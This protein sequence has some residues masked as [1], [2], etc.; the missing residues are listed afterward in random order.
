MVDDGNSGR[1]GNQGQG[2]P[3]GK[4]SNAGNAFESLAHTPDGL[5]QALLFRS[6]LV[7]L[8]EGRCRQPDP[9]LSA[10]NPIHG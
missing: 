9:V 8:T 4:P 3:H 10:F 5:P 7:R 2:Q 6:H 1:N